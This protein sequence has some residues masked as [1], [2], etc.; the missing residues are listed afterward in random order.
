MR[1][2][3]VKDG[4]P[5]RDYFKLKAMFDEF[6]ALNVKVVKLELD[7]GDYASVYVAMHTIGKSA[8]THGYPVKTSVR[9]GE[10]YMIRTDM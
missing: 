8:K 3:V 10:V 4:V 1:M 5:K 2:V 7:E 9:N 6:M